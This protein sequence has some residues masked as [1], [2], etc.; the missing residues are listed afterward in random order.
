[1]DWISASDGGG[2]PSLITYC[3]VYTVTDAL[4]R[5]LPGRP[6]PH[7]SS[8]IDAASGAFQPAEPRCSV[9]VR[10]ILFGPVN[11]ILGW[12]P[13]CETNDGV[14]VATDGDGCNEGTSLIEGALQHDKV[15]A[16]GP[17]S[18]VGQL[19]R[20]CANPMLVASVASVLLSL[21]GK[22]V[23]R[24][25]RS[26]DFLLSVPQYRLAKPLSVGT[27][28]T[29]SLRLQFV[30]SAV[31]QTMRTAGD[32]TT[33]LMLANL[34]AGMALQMKSAAEDAESTT[35]SAQQTGRLSRNL[36]VAVS[37]GRMCEML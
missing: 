7:S 22:R 3:F 25:D 14:E 29:E 8:A 24:V 17:G 12:Q 36:V 6:V 31:W 15:P 33:P 28:W 9:H 18:V 16:N 34:G 5:S 20:S 4:V 19:A 11:F 26:Y 37:W 2:K 32:A 13:A 21:V 10:Q 23:M 1:M 35:T 30:G 27:A